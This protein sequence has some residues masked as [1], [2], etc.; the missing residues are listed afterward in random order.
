MA[1]QGQNFANH[2]RFVPP[3]H[4]VAGPIF[5]INFGWAIY[6]LFGGISFQVILNVL[7]AFALVILFLYARVFALKAQDRLIRLEMRLRMR[8]L[9]PEDLQGRI[10]D[11]TATQMVGLR[12]ASDRELPE[13]ARKVLDE[14]I[15]TATPIKK[16]VTDW[17][18]DYCRVQASLDCES[19]PDDR[20]ARDQSG[21]VATRAHPQ[22]PRTRAALPAGSPRHDD[23]SIPPFGTRAV[24]NRRL[25]AKVKGGET[26]AGYTTIGDGCGCCSGQWRS[27]SNAHR[28][29]PSEPIDSRR[30]DG[31]GR[32]PCDA[33][34]CRSA[35][36]SSKLR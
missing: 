5:L 8:E 22:I 30:D 29:H 6:G 28:S 17:Q 15:T 2:A 4:Y 14:N 18:G 25:R 23:D 12:F 9:L 16:L 11:F 36:D 35:Y 1:D 21:V 19:A 24:A 7:V 27:D 3:Y 31:E 20:A 33:I 32:H 34:P 26:N 13:L 10:N